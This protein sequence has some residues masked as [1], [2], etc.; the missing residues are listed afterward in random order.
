MLSG[1]VG[2]L[3]ELSSEGSSVRLASE[4]SDESY[5]ALSDVSTILNSPQGMRK[6]AYET[7]RY[8]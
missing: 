4:T 5:S 2:N 7:Q 8:L 6:N 1:V 3:L